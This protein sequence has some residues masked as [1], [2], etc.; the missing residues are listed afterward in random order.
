MQTNQTPI[1]IPDG[2]EITKPGTVGYAEGDE[3]LRYCRTC[4]EK[5]KC[6]LN[7]NLRLAMGEDCPYW[8]EEFLALEIKME[9]SWRTETRIAC[10]NYE[11]QQMKLPGIPQPFCDG[12]E[13]LVEK[14]RLEKQLR[15][16]TTEPKCL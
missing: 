2:F 14:I 6:G 3:I 12:I 5:P 4:T 16:S 11:N 1:R 8:A 15:E 10:I 7:Y 9:E 13:K